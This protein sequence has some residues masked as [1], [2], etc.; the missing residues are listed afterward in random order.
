M[1][2]DAP[3]ALGARAVTFDDDEPMWRTIERATLDRL[4][5]PEDFAKHGWPERWEPMIE[6]RVWQAGDMCV[7]D[8]A[9]RE[10]GL[11]R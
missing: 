5:T 2:V 6:L 3:R 8:K 10:L 7:S 11:S 9:A 1:D 4:K